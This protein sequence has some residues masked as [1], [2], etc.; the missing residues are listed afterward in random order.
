[1]SLDNNKHLKEVEKILNDWNDKEGYLTTNDIHGVDLISQ[2]DITKLG[3]ETEDEDEIAELL[4]THYDGSDYYFQRDKDGYHEFALVISTCEEI[5]ITFEGD[6]C[7]PDENTKSVKLSTDNREIEIIA[8][9]LEWMHDNGCFPSIYELDYYSN[10]PTLYNFYETEE[11]K[12]LSD[13]DE[14]QKKEVARLVE[15]IE[16]QKT[17]EEATQTLCDLPHEFYESMPEVLQENDGY[18][19]V[20][21]VDS[22]DSYTMKIEFEVEENEDDIITLLRKGTITQGENDAS[23]TITIS[24]LPNSVRFM[25]GLDDMLGLEVA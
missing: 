21:S 9:A 25:K 8:Y 7:F 14:K 12:S 11:Y 22:F 23:Y 4:E 3:L 5:F 13:E 10:S 6:L 15:I 20:L 19:E 2:I 18:I 24:L 1:M 16:F 17:L